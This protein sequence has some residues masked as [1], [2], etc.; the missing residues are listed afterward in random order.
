MNKIH[1]FHSVEVI[2]LR[3][4]SNLRSEEVGQGEL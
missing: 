2:T 3:L 4:V 1:I